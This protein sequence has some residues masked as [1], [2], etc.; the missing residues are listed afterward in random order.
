MTRSSGPTPPHTGPG[1][2]A[3]TEAAGSTCRDPRGTCYLAS[4]AVVAVR[5]RLGTVLGGQPVV[6]AS[7]LDDV[8]VSTL[9]LP[10]RT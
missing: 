5:E 2:S 3:A 8:V 9:H 10:R 7:L 4:S 6:P 1:G